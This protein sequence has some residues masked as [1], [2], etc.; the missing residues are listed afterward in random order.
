[1]AVSARA[2]LVLAAAVAQQHLACAGTSSACPAG[3]QSHAPGYWH[4]SY[5]SC[6][7]SCPWEDHENV[8]A[9][10]CAKKCST[11][12]G[13]GSDSTA[14]G[15]DWQWLQC[16][17]FEVHGP[18]AGGS[19]A[20]CFLFLG[21]CDSPFT[22]YDPPNA[23]VT[24]CVVDGYT[25]GPGPAPGPPPP[26]PPPPAPPAPG[27]PPPPPQPPPPVVPPVPGRSTGVDCP[28]LGSCWG[29]DVAI[30]DKML[31]YI[32]F[33]GMT[34]DTWARYDTIFINPFDSCCYLKEMGSWQAHIRAIKKGNPSAK[35]LAT[36]HATEIWAEDINIANRWLPPKCLMRNA[37]GTPCSWWAGLVFTNN[38]FIEECWQY[39]VDNAMRAL[40]G[41]LME[42]GVDGVFLD[43]FTHYSEGCKSN[44][45]VAC[46][47]VPD[48]PTGSCDC[49]KVA[50]PANVTQSQW[51]QKFV[52]WFDVLKAK[53]PRLLWVNNIGVEDADAIQNIT[54]GR[55]I[56]GSTNV[57]E[58][59]GLNKIIDGTFPIGN[60][61]DYAASWERTGLKP[62]LL[63]VSVNSLIAGEGWRIG[64]W[65]NIATK[66]EM[67]L[68]LTKFARLRMG[69]GVALLTNAFFAND[70]SGM[71]CK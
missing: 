68:H 45:N 7:P 40:D 66:G 71:F 38:L 17:A 25:P 8:T 48:T 3:F 32:G 26:P 21:S 10:L 63:H 49:S 16:V 59:P 54:N 47:C 55:Q 62:T 2:G 14:G 37:D 18:E 28:R 43:G 24:T 20:A 31:N 22:S 65:Q 35:V 33:P 69:L 23:N 56:E 1:M 5:P 52:R 44:P 36:F 9:A 41:G 34:N 12:R 51:V 29:T 53:Y 70:I 67:M 11:W 13:N 50:P 4:N 27:P 6:R 60:Y 57:A 61:V 46:E 42:A 58:S 30:T 39:A 15:T 64:R 19:L